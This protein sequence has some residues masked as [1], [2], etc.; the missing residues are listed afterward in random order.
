MHN[1]SYSPWFNLLQLSIQFY[2]WRLWVPKIFLSSK[3]WWRK[4]MCLKCLLTKKIIFLCVLQLNWTLTN[5]FSVSLYDIFRKFYF[6]FQGRRKKSASYVLFLHGGENHISFLVSV[7]DLE[8]SCLISLWC[9]FYHTLMKSLTYGQS[10]SRFLFN[11][12]RSF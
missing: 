10:F 2:L 9:H 3:P 5:S 8:D 6:E 7:F 12:I 1:R 4:H 11:P